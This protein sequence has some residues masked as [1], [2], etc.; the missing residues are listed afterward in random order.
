[1]NTEASKSYVTVLQL[2]DLYYIKYINVFLL[3]INLLQ[4]YVQGIPDKFQL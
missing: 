4:L 3:K 2:M 1:M